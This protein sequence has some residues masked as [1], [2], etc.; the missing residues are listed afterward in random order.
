MVSS[1]RPNHF[2]GPVVHEIQGL[3][4]EQR[5]KMRQILFW[6]LL[7]YLQLTW[8]GLAAAVLLL[9]PAGVLGIVAVFA[10][11]SVVGRRPTF[12]ALHGALLCGMIVSAIQSESWRLVADFA[13]L[14]AVT[15]LELNHSRPALLFAI[16]GEHV[17]GLTLDPWSA[18]TLMNS[19]EVPFVGAAALFRLFSIIMIVSLWVRVFVLPRFMSP[20]PLTP[21]P[22]RS[23]PLT[24]AEWEARN[25]HK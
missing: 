19:P 13:A 16:V 24:V 22:E 15:T 3:G 25:A 11:H 8:F 5:R 23:Q 7:V 2:L 21:A 12:V 14:G 20:P 9:V 17:L 6:V 10:D 4:P 18:I 1:S